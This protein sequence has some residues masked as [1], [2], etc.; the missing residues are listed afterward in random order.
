MP[1]RCPPA[2][3]RA[4]TGSRWSASATSAA[5]RWPTSCSPRGSPTPGS[6]TGSRS[7]APAPAAGTSATRWTARAAATL[8]AAGYDAS[9]HR[10]QQFDAGL[11]RRPRPG[12]GDGRA[13]TSPTVA[14]PATRRGSGCSATSTRS[15]RVATCPTRT[16]VGTTAS[17]RCWRWSS[18]PA[19]AIVAALRCDE[20]TATG[21]GRP[22]TRQPLVAR[23]AEE[24][25][26]AAVV[27]TAPVAGGDIATAT[28]LRLSDGTTALMKTLPARAR[29]ASSS[30]E[31]AGLRWLAEAE[32]GVAVPEVLAR[33]PRVP[34]PRAGSSPARPPSTR[35]PPSA[36]RWPPRTRPARRRTALDHDG[37]IGRLPLPNRTAPTV[38]RSSTPSAGC[39]PTSSSPATGAPITDERR[40]R[41]RVGRR[42][43]RRPACPRSRPPGCTATSGTATCSGAS[44]ARRRLIDP[45]AHGGHR[46][47]D[48]AMLRAVRAAAPAAGA[49][50]PTTRRTPL[51]DGWED[52]LGAAPAVPAA[53][54]RLPC[55]AAA[56]A[57]A[58]PTARAPGTPDATA[59]SQRR[60]RLRLAE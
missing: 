6:P 48:L 3:A 1:A 52:R 27:A 57:P 33:R 31:A 46:E 38:G 16:T 41:R 59:R 11:A 55:S 43:A 24:L 56:T 28:R 13:P 29:R 23:R 42:P 14:R 25:L 32:G 30:A 54:A 49:R 19:T 18:A 9:R 58:R 51:A 21:G 53:R 44:T 45:A 17:R 35:P 15:N 37:F 8:T 50:R 5:R 12:A 39:C 2:R 7:P 10:A 47:T 4:A 36:A 40:R 20:P 26:G 34:D 60:L 22:M